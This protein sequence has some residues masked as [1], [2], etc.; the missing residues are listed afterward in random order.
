MKAANDGHIEIAE[1]LVKSNA[2]LNVQSWVRS[3]KYYINIKKRPSSM[4]SREAI[5][6]TSMERCQV[7][8]PMTIAI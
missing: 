3:Y 5:T 7:S 4:V 8:I 2:D 1:L 6:A